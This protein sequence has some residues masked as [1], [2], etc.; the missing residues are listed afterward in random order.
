MHVDQPRTGLVERVHLPGPCSE[1]CRY[2]EL[3]LLPEDGLLPE[4]M[5]LFINKRALDIARTAIERPQSN[6]GSKFPL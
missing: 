2:A 3:D 4:E 1:E 6:L 5:R